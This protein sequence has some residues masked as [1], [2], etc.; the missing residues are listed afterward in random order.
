MATRP[1]HHHEFK[2]HDVT[3]DHVVF[4]CE[5]CERSIGFW[6]PDSGKTPAVTQ[7]EDGSYAIAP[8]DNER[9]G[10]IDVTIGIC[11]K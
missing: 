4:K 2:Q 3:D 9:G 11:D 6:K 10:A 7:L 5:H 8:S 1:F